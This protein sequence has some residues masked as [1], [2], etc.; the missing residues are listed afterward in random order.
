MSKLLKTPLY[1]AHV[2]LNGKIVPFAGY[3][4]P[5]QYADGALKEYTAVRNGEAGIFD[6][7]HMGQVRVS[8]PESLAFLQYVTTNDVAKLVDGQ[9]QYSALLNVHGT[10]VDDI[11]TYKIADAHYYLCINAANRHKD[12]AHL[13]VE[14]ANFDVIVSDESDSTTL[15]AL[16][17]AKA[18]AAL[19]PLLQMSLDDIGYYKFAVTTLDGHEI[20]VS[21]TGYTGEDGFEIYLPNALAEKVWQALLDNGAVPIGLAA[22]DMLRTEMGYALYGHEI[23]DGVTPVE[24]R[25]MWITK[26]DKGDFIGK[27]AV[28]ARKAEGPQ[29]RL[30]AIKL[31]GRGIPREHY[32]VWVDGVESGEVTSGMHSPMAGGVAL[33]YV[34]PEHAEQG[35][36]SVDIRGKLIPAERTGLPFVRSNV[37]K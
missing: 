25:L 6:I 9:V 37:K 2:A 16:Q 36:I 28:A 20:I 4:L 22:R 29:Q 27:A 5:V 26:L 33:A 11:T 31:T 3:E 18:Q 23:H 14:A 21:R 32:K 35:D 34:K 10:F 13:Q 24:A 1:A 8:G 7:T 17:G 15:L 30:I 12:V 19:Q